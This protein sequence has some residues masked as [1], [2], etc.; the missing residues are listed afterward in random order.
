M[1][2]SG[3]GRAAGLALPPFALALAV[4]LPFVLWAPG[5]PGADGA[6]Y[7]QYARILAAGAGFVNL[8]G[9]P[10]IR[11]MPGW[12]LVLGG[13]YRLFGSD[14]KVGMWANAG[15]DAGAAALLALLGARL[16]GRRT[17]LLAGGL[18]AAWPGMAYYAATSFAEPLFN[19][20]W[21]GALLLLA[22]AG[23]ADDR[24]PQRFAAAGALLGLATL[25][26]AE[27]PALGPA[28]LVYLWRV[29]R[30][31]SDF[32]RNAVALGALA[33]ALIGPWTVRNY[34]VFG[35]FVPTSASGAIGAQL[36]NHPGASGAQDF[37]LNRA[38]QQRYRGRTSA[39]TT[40]NRYDAGF[41]DAWRFARENPR[42]QLAI[43]ANKFRVTYGGDGQ[44]AKTI[45]G[46]G[47]QRDWHLSPARWRRLTLGADAY[48]FAGLALAAVGLA[49]LRGAAPGTASL[50]LGPLVTWWALHV[51]FLAGQR[52]HVPEIP[53]YA[54]LAACGV[55]TLAGRL[56]GRAPAAQPPKEASP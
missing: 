11:W 7:H 43:V 25:V 31:P 12:P 45:R 51:V 50:L 32:A 6:F 33:A 28:L 55:L 49:T 42:E 56:R 9:S 47:R 44:A 20:L 39:E 26:K 2:D 40:I 29:R 18:Y 13:L 48:W 8:D 37:R 17:G 23:A 21:V 36:A 1:A 4:R 24:R 35:R 15:F 46:S 5:V 30:S 38:L 19:G 53:I 22:Q 10:H 41:A 34:V 14:P 52:Y 16:F 27:V 54:L 3:R